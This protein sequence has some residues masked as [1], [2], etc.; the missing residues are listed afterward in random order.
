MEIDMLTK[1]KKIGVDMAENLEKY[2]HI[3]TPSK[4]RRDVWKVE[5]IGKLAGRK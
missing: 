4:K 1:V 3:I 5:N 2:N